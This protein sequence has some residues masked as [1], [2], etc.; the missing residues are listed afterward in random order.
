MRRSWSTSRYRRYRRRRYSGQRYSRQ[1]TGPGSGRSTVL[2]GSTFFCNVYAAPSDVAVINAGA[3]MNV[4]YQTLSVLMP[5]DPYCLRLNTGV[6]SFTGDLWSWNLTAED[7]GQV[8]KVVSTDFQYLANACSGLGVSS[9]VV[10]MRPPTEAWDFKPSTLLGHPLNQDDLGA[11]AL[12]EA[13]NDNVITTYSGGNSVV[14]WG[15]YGQMYD[16]Y[17]VDYLLFEYVPSCSRM[18]DGQVTMLWNDNPTDP[19]PSTQGQFLQNTKCVTTQIYNKA[20]LVVKPRRWLWTCPQAGNTGVRTLSVKDQNIE[21]APYT[22]RTVDTGWFSVVA[23]SSAN[24]TELSVV[25]SI[26][27]TYVVRFSKPSINMS[28]VMPD[29]RTDGLIVP[30]ELVQPASPGARQAAPP[31]V[32]Y[33]PGILRPENQQPGAQRDAVLRDDRQPLRLE[34]SSRMIVTGNEGSQLTTNYQVNTRVMGGGGNEFTISDVFG[35][36]YIGNPMYYFATRAAQLPSDPNNP[37]PDP[38]P[39]PGPDVPDDPVPPEPD[40]PVGS[41]KAYVV[42]RSSPFYRPGDSGNTVGVV[43]VGSSSYRPPV[44]PALLP[45]Q[46]YGQSFDDLGKSWPPDSSGATPVTPSSVVGFMTMIDNDANMS[47]PKPGQVVALFGTNVT[48]TQKDLDSKTKDLT[49][50]KNRFLYHTGISWSTIS[51]LKLTTGTY[52]SSFSSSPNQFYLA[53]VWQDHASPSVTEAFYYYSGIVHDFMFM[54]LPQFSA[55]GVTYY[56]T[57]AYGV[58]RRFSTNLFGYTSDTSS[59]GTASSSSSI[60][61]VSSSS[62]PIGDGSSGNP[63]DVSDSPTSSNFNVWSISSSIPTKFGVFISMHLA[64]TRVATPFILQTRA[65]MAVTR[66]STGGDALLALW[67]TGLSPSTATKITWPPVSGVVGNATVFESGLHEQF[68]DAFSTYN[69]LG[70][71]HASDDLAAFTTKGLAYALSFT[72]DVSSVSGGGSLFFVPSVMFHLADAES[73]GLVINNFAGYSTDFETLDFTS[74]SPQQPSRASYYFVAG[75]QF[76]IISMKCV[77][78][79]A[80][81]TPKGLSNEQLGQYLA[82]HPS[83]V[84]MASGM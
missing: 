17:K 72:C 73:T 10:N 20:Q 30:R 26:K 25:G 81:A 44:D 82:D 53:G 59:F 45:G 36:N 23:R 63:I 9:R 12:W 5:S 77:V 55:Y 3:S 28:M 50:P 60:F 31:G 22:D 74:G 75:A 76:F 83:S 69:G 41:M 32:H 71:E 11:G 48:Y 64:F 35:S 49:W 6:C 80:D 16:R 33:G 34:P 68:I 78:Y 29:P 66:G 61:C 21:A 62:V 39:G 42:M 27:V 13:F 46:Q 18:T 56:G 7:T 19:I 24:L 79:D 58:F 8:Y 51:P 57:E 84:V 4:R 1:W 67:G 47:S 43:K 52:V 40:V 65:Y 54:F 37:D 15:Q 14:Q 70:D 38:D 2:K